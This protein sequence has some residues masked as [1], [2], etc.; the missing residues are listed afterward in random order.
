M[1]TKKP[2]NGIEQTLE[3]FLIRIA[4]ALHLNLKED[5]CQKAVQFLKFCIVG[6]SNTAVSYTVNITTLKLVGLIIPGLKFDYVIANVT[7][8]LVAVYWSFYWNS[9][10][11]F[12]FQTDDKALRR[13]AL[14]RTY[15]CYGFTG[16]ILNNILSTIWINVLGISKL[17]SPL[18]NL[19]FTIPINY[20][21]NKRWAFGIKSEE[22]S[23]TRG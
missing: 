8:F 9:R 7:A 12:H 11:V 1:S 19:V 5:A 20:L 13:K 4:R 18:M 14:L 2:E 6:V 3:S 15:M 23:K 16:I 17:I 10:K 22:G 21:T